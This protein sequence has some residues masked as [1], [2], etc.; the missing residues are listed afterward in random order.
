[1]YPLSGILEAVMVISFGISWP[2]SIVKS[3]QSRTAKGKSI[4]FLLMI[5]FGYICGILSKIALGHITYVFIFYV[6]NLVMVG[7][8]VALYFRNKRIDK[9]GLTQN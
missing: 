7:V 4:F 3:I 1:M 2:I 6:L 9:K 8:D 5:F